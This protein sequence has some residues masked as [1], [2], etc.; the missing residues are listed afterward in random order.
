M[1]QYYFTLYFVGL[2]SISLTREK[3][4]IFLLLTSSTNREG[5]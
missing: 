5:N 3:A 4:T 2:V 1:Q